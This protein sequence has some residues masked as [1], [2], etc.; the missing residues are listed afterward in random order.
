[1]KA[2]GYGSSRPLNHCVPGVQC[3]EEEHAVNR[4][5]EFVVTGVKSS[6]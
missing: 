6:N 5:N 3:T 1:M 4:R 2:T